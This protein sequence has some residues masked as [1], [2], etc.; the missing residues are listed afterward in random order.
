MLLADDDS[1]VEY[2]KGNFLG[3]RDA[4]TID[5]I[6]V[7]SYFGWSCVHLSFASRFSKAASLITWLFVRRFLEYEI[8]LSTCSPC[9]LADA[10]PHLFVQQLR[11]GERAAG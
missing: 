9:S 7:R 6:D 1:R 11:V 8:S 4:M 10:S 2:F 5:K 3:L